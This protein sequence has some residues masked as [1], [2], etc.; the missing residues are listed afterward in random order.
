M[1]QIVSDYMSVYRHC[2]P[3]I[4]R[5]LT[6]KHILC[7]RRVLQI[8]QISVYICI[9]GT[10]IGIAGLECFFSVKCSLF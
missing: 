2:S 1:E 7:E 3:C 10:M 4:S 8:M 6:V 5:I 9:L